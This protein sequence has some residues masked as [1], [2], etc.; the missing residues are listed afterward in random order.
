MILRSLIL[1]LLLLLVASPALAQQPT[2]PDTA[3]APP[4][5]HLAP[6]PAPIQQP[7]GERYPPVLQ[8]IVA[9]LCAVLVL[10][11]V[12]KPSRKGLPT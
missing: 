5:P 8:T 9:V 4:P 2:Q 12:C 3:P 11:V 6:G 10:Y 1:A 7:Q